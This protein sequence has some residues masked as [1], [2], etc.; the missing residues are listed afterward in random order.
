MYAIN[1]SHEI[2]RKQ[3]VHQIQNCATIVRSKIHLVSVETFIYIPRQE[4]DGLSH[5]ILPLIEFPP[6]I[7]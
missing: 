3:K 6:K 2:T 5:T 1:V 7:N 4:I